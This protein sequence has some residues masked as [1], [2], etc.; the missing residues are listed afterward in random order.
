MG[1]EDAF[2]LTAPHMNKG[3]KAHWTPLALISLP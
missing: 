3:D 2:G 1:L